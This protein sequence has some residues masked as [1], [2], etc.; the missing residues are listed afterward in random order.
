MGQRMI[1][2]KPGPRPRGSVLDPVPP[3]DIVV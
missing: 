1:G 3:Y 2:Q